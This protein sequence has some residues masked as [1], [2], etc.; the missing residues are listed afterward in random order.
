MV[1]YFALF[2]LPVSFRPDQEKVKKQFYRLSRQYHP[3]YFSLENEED[4]S[5]VLE[6]SADINK[7]YRILRDP[8]AIMKFVLQW[9]G[10]LEEEE[11]YQLD[12]GFLMQ[13][14]ELNEVIMDAKMEENESITIDLR[15]QIDSLQSEIY[16]PVK[17]IV[18]N[19]QEGITTPEDLLRVKEYYFRKK[20]LNRILEGMAG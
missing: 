10:L 17:E 4:Q 20:Y 5:A 19:Y 18:E 6:K 1:N 11:K 2:E 3:D 13:V 16:R 15:K 9:K 8:D 14:M 12:S 7:G